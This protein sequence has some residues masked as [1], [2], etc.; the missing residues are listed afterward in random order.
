MSD[1]PEKVRRVV[2]AGKVEALI[3]GW[4]KIANN[5][6]GLG[7]PQ[8]AGIYRDFTGSLRDLLPGDPV[9]DVTQW[10]CF[11]CDEVFTDRQSAWEHFGEENCTTDV[12][13][14]IDPLRTDEKARMK[15][16]REARD[17]VWRAQAEQDEAETD[18]ALY[19]QMRD[20]IGRLFGECAGVVAST[21]HQAWLKLDAAHGE[22][23]AL[24]ERLAMVP[25]VT[26]LLEA[27]RDISE[28][29]VYESH[30][31]GQVIDASNKETASA[32]LADFEGN[33]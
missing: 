25:D 23:I 32:A 10:R 17:L 24:K 3:L 18:A 27:L 8:L 30:D 7:I 15:E 4:H 14:C 16:L 2:D 21:P 12:P 13:A 22:I 29:T 28:A 33:R 1:Q 5:Y 11:H 20:E 31:V 19:H 9:P 6:E 26:R